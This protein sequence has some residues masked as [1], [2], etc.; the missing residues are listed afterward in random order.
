ML[1]YKIN[2]RNIKRDDKPIDVESSGGVPFV[3]KSDV[4]TVNSPNHGL[5][6]GDTVRFARS[7]GRDIQF[8]YQTEVNSVVTADRF[9]IPT[10]KNRVLQVNAAGVEKEKYHYSMMVH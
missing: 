3:W 5:E 8:L 9:T 7:D 4:I 2:A 6:V 10:F 1:T